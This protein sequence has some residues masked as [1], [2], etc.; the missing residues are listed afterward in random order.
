MSDSF[1]TVL[2]NFSLPDRSMLRRSKR[3]GFI[4]SGFSS[5]AACVVFSYAARLVFFF[6]FPRL[7]LLSVS[8]SSSSSVQVL[9]AQQDSLQHEGQ[10][11]GFVFWRI[12]TTLSEP[13]FCVFYHMFS[14]WV[15]FRVCDERFVRVTVC[16]HV[17]F[18]SLSFPQL[19]SPV[20][21]RVR[22]GF[23]DSK[24]RQSE[25]HFSSSSL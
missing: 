9:D 17:F 4:H 23:S 2:S 22:S 8:S 20:R 18:S 1:W 24:V 19:T 14:F 5:P 3:Y 7:P 11:T 25:Q 15:R 12:N 6:F 16:R 10:L 13:E 21:V